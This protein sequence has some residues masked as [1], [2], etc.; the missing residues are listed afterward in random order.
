M[1]SVSLSVPS[2]VPP[3]PQI[4][5]TQVQTFTFLFDSPWGAAGFASVV[6]NGTNG[7]TPFA[8]SLAL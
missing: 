5:P 6:S 4:D 1:T 2:P 8:G 3:R 7:K